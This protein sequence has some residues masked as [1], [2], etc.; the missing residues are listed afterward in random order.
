MIHFISVNIKNFRSYKNVTVDFRKESGIYIFSGDNGSGKSTFLNAINWCLYGDTP[1]FSVG[2]N[3]E[4][5]NI[6][7]GD[8]DVTEVNLWVNINDNRYLFSR[9]TRKGAQPAGVLSVQ[10]ADEDS[11]NW[12][13][14]SGASATD[15]VMRFVPKDIRQ[16]FFFNGEQLKDIYSGDG[17]LKKNVYK[18][19]ELDVIDNA[20]SNLETVERAYLGQIKKDSTNRR[21]IEELEDDIEQYKSGINGC[22]EYLAELKSKIEENQAKINDLNKFI[23]D[24]SEAKRMLEDEKNLKE[25]IDDIT[26]TL[27]ALEENQNESFITNFHAA[28]LYDDFKKYRKKLDEAKE[29]K[30]IPPP[31]DPSITQESLETG[32]CRCCNTPLTEETIA[33]IK[34]QHDEYKRR[35]ELQFL[36]DG[37]NEFSNVKYRLNSEVY[38]YADLLDQITA[39]KNKKNECGQKLKKIQETL[40]LVDRGKLQD[41]PEVKRTHLEN[42]IRTLTIKQVNAGNQLNQH[43]DNLREAQI[44]LSRLNRNDKATEILE[45]KRLYTELL[46]QKL[47]TIKDAMEIMIRRKLESNIWDSFSKILPGTVFTGVSISENYSVIMK[48]DNGKRY[49]VEMLSTGQAKVLGLAL[50]N[51]L[52]T[53]LGYA[54]VPLLIDNLYGDIDAEHFEDVSHM[55]ES[56]SSQKQT[57]IM[58][59]MSINVDTTFDSSRIVQEFNIKKQGEASLI[60]EINNA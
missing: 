20:I 56:L 39:G 17:T 29:K 2:E 14:L 12:R 6:S 28:L 49:T 51:A 21:R 54:E 45:K 15:A 44:E 50:V 4:V 60:E 16:L 33:F 55:I 5:V 19:S 52:S 1:F 11:G 32:V 40:E 9:K 23:Q 31:I 7:A 41:N 27:K 22:T 43:K 18:V 8:N 25:E 30:L 58:N 24:N 59:L 3:K 48:S 42:E 38:E 57:I 34:E 37:I 13:E 35:S 10:V 36:T 53:D 46:I 26:S 47:A